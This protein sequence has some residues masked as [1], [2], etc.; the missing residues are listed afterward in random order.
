MIESI[1]ELEASNRTIDEELS[2]DPIEE[3]KEMIYSEPRS[4]VE[5]IMGEV[6]GSGQQHVDKLADG[7][8]LVYTKVNKG[9]GACKV[10]MVKDG[11]TTNLYE[12]GKKDENNHYIKPD[13]V[14]EIVEQNKE[15][16]IQNKR[17]ELAQH[18]GHQE[19]DKDNRN[20]KTNDGEVL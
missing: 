17:M 13:K 7:S 5:R 19:V 14:V 4:Y 6:R 3:M 12:P 8:E 1:S 20:I 10:D 18:L 15:A 2:Y 11:Q 9:Y 16:I